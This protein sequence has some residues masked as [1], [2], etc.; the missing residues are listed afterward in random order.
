MVWP[1]AR[2]NYERELEN[3]ASKIRQNQLKISRLSSARRR[4]KGLFLLYSITVYL[5]YLT[6][7]ATTGRLRKKQHGTLV[8]SLPVII[9]FVQHLVDRV[10]QWLIERRMNTQTALTTDRA[11][12]IEKYKEKTDYYKIRKVLNA[13]EVTSSDTEPS[14]DLQEET[15]FQEREN[16]PSGQPNAASVVTPHHRTWVDRLLDV[17][18]GEN[19]ES[20]DLRYALICSSCHQHNGLA[21]YGQVPEQV[22]YICPR[23]GQVNGDNFEE[24]LTDF[25]APETVGKSENTDSNENI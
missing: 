20:P 22:K 18:L 1:F 7:V 17:I 15:Y 8:A 16:E 5:F 19:E 4:F 12:L 11:D 2:P 13:A 21:P 24:N 23:C 3:L 9:F 14:E 6:V 10:Y 25:T